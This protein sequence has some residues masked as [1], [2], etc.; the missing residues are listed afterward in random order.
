ML[1]GHD[2]QRYVNNFLK[3][4]FGNSVSKWK[5]LPDIQVEV[6]G[7]KLNL[8]ITSGKGVWYKILD[9]K[10]RNVPLHAV[11]V[12]KLPEYLDLQIEELK[13]RLG[14]NYTPTPILE[15]NEKLPDELIK[16][17]QKLKE[18]REG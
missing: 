2:F 5:G 17:A 11:I 14:K 6:N 16:I 8:E 3:K 12:K 15:F 7:V 13:K 1:W 9:Y 18:E 4:R 10:E